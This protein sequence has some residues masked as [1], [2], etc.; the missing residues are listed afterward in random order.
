[1]QWNF[2]LN[3]NNKKWLICYKLKVE[4]SFQYFTRKREKIMFF[5]GF[6][7][8]FLNS[9]K[10]LFT[11]YKKYEC[12]EH[13]FFLK[14]GIELFTK[15]GLL[16]LFFWGPKAYEEM[17]L[18][19]RNLI[20]WELKALFCTSKMSGILSFSLHSKACAINSSLNI[21]IGRP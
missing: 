4:I 1:L 7:F 11:W 17:V 5:S 10:M 14:K 19:F 20:P 3:G 9:N 12:F 8:F 15:R 16:L 13:E 6:F 18:V 2:C 21:Y